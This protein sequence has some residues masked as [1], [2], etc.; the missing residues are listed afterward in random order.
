MKQTK[1]IK[2]QLP[3]E[4]KGDSFS[5]NTLAGSNKSKNL[6]SS[7]CKQSLVEQGTEF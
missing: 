2:S 4:E 6:N 7:P 1:A 3:Q 5:G